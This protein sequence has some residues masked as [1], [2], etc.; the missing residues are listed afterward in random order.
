MLRLIVR[1]SLPVLAVV[2]S[3]TLQPLQAQQMKVTFTGTVTSGFGDAYANTFNSGPYQPGRSLIG[4]AFTLQYFYDVGNLGP[5]LA[6][7]GNQYYSAPSAP[8]FLS[9]TVSVGGV[10]LTM[11]TRKRASLSV[12]DAPDAS[13]YKDNLGI[14]GGTGYHRFP[15]I[16]IEDSFIDLTGFGAIADGSPFSPGASRSFAGSGLTGYFYLLETAACSAPGGPC[17]Q[18][19]FNDGQT[20]WVEIGATGTSLQFEAVSAVPEPASMALVGTGLL[21]V[22]GLARRRRTRG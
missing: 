16:E 11:D 17:L 5:N 12:T 19:R 13:G 4:Q 20:H 2:A 8:T 22:A 3:A 15:S 1:T 6:S 21:V 9:G 7:G 10:T 14:S 18:G